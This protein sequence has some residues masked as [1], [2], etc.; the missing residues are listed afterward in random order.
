MPT[1]IGPITPTSP[2]DVYEVVDTQYVKGGLNTAFVNPGDWENTANLP[3][4]RRRPGMIV[5]AILDPTKHFVLGEDNVTWTPLG[6]ELNFD[7]VA[8]LSVYSSNTSITEGAKF[9]FVRG[10]HADRP[11]LGAAKWRLDPLSTRTVGPDCLQVGASGAGRYIVIFDGGEINVT[12]LGAKPAAINSSGDPTET[13]TTETNAAFQRAI[14]LQ[15]DA[16]IYEKMIYVPT[17]AGV[18]QISQTITSSVTIAIPLQI[19]GDT[20]VVGGTDIRTRGGSTIMMMTSNTPIIEVA[21]ECNAVY[22]LGLVYSSTQS[23][24]N[25]NAN[26][27]Q[28][29]SGTIVWYSRFEHLQ[30][31][32][33]A[34]GIFMGVSGSSTA[35]NNSYRNIKV[36]RFS[37]CAI[38]LARSG[39][40]SRGSHWYIQNNSFSTG[41]NATITNVTKSGTQLTLTLNAIPANLK[42]GSMGD[43]NG[44][45]S[46][47]NGQFFVKTI[48]GNQITVDLP[49]D[50]GGTVTD[51]SGTFDFSFGASA[52]EP[53]VKF[54]TGCEIDIDSVDIEI[55]TA[56]TTANGAI[57]LDNQGMAHIGFLHL[58]YFQPNAA[59]QCIIRSRG[60]TLDIDAI[61]VVNCGVPSGSTMYLVTAEMVGA[62]Q[63]K[64]RIGLLSVRDIANIGGTFIIARSLTTANKV[65]IDQYDSFLTNRANATGVWSWGDAI[66]PMFANGGTGRAAL[67]GTGVLEVSTGS[68]QTVRTLPQA[69][70]ANQ[71]LTREAAGLGS[72]VASNTGRYAGEALYTAIDEG[73][74]VSVHRITRTCTDLQLCYSSLIQ[75]AAYANPTEIGQ[76]PFEL[77]VSL[78]KVQSNYTTEIG[79]PVYLRF[80]HTGRYWS[81]LN[82]AGNYYTEPLGMLFNAGDFVRVMTYCNICKSDTTTITTNGIAETGNLTALQTYWPRNGVYG[83]TLTTNNACGVLSQNTGT[84]NPG[85]YNRTNGGVIAITAPGGYAPS[86]IIGRP[87]DSGSG[88]NANPGITLLG[89]SILNNSTDLP[90]TDEAIG[91][92][93]GYFMRGVGTSRSVYRAATGGSEVRYLVGDYAYNLAVRG[94]MN[95]RSQIAFLGFNGG[96]DLVTGRT[97][98]QLQADY[99]LLFAMLRSV[100]YRK[101]ITG[102]LTPRTSSTDGWQTLANQTQV[103]VGYDTSALAVNTWLAA[104]VGVL[105]DGHCDFTSAVADTSGSTFRWKVSTLP[106]NY[107]VNGVPS[108]TVVPVAT[109]LTANAWINYSLL[110]GTT[111]RRII[112]NTTTA[113]TVEPSYGFTPAVASTVTTLRCRVDGDDNVHPT[114][115]GHAD[116]ATVIAANLGTMFVL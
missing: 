50:P 58:E 97:S 103:Y 76:N 115:F 3:N 37:I 108:S 2:L 36:N 31:N 74:T 42:T 15:Q 64:T 30:F 82:A 41:Q 109:A 52:T 20:A 1:V 12:Q 78:V 54:G 53:M 38:D 33:C 19:R 11:G 89:D 48:S 112:S 107:T 94:Q 23:S 63:S 71:A 100:G 24:S 21:D 96:N 61:T 17:S 26:G 110:S 14:L 91:S 102:S 34:R 25:T 55:N 62:F 65:I 68:L 69:V 113:F 60:T 9:V 86:A 72:L 80:T 8:D 105:T 44:L 4:D 13:F 104:Q 45:Q 18:Y 84:I 47:F 114:G 67:G 59:N 116:M 98:A 35:P 28:A 87:L 32:K 66:Q 57:A 10:Y 46:G 70:A 16:G 7:S 90:R 40:C 111:T 85:T 106:T 95:S 101:I 27:I 73:T 5:S 77:I 93:N 39:T 79:A 81:L 99:T 51:T 6:S 29:R 88:L 75:P 92:G 49:S 56:N 83:G 43:V 22:G